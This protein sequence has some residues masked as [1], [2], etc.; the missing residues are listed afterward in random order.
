[1]R[2]L[3]L[4]AFATFAFSFFAEWIE[5]RSLSVGERATLRALSRRTVLRVPVRGLPRHAPVDD[6][7]ASS[8]LATFSSAVRVEEEINA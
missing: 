3:A 2:T 6:R 1:M 4:F 8:A 7:E 5:R